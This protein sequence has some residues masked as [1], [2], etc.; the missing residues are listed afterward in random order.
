MDADHHQPLRFLALGDPTR[1]RAQRGF[2][3]GA[4]RSVYRHHYCVFHSGSRQ[5]SGIPAGPLETQGRL[6]S[7]PF[8]L[9]SEYEQCVVLRY[10]R[11]RTLQQSVRI[12]D[13]TFVAMDVSGFW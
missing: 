9:S 1:V 6:A 7:K 2:G 12:F 3:P 10:V 8:K 4:A 13:G 5:R 11:N